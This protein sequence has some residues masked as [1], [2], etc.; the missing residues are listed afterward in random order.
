MK[1]LD[2]ILLLITALLA[3]YQVVQGIA[4]LSSMA[5]A[6]YTI[7][8]GV[9]VI[10]SLM[11]LIL[12]FEVLDSPLVVIASTLIPL[13]LALG[14]VAQFIRP[15][16]IPYGIFTVMGF[17]AIVATRL[18]G[19]KK[20]AVITLAVVHGVAGLTIFFLP[21]VIA[22][23][24]KTPGGFAWVGIGGMLIGLGGLLLSFLKAGKPLLSRGRILAVFPGLLLLTTA[25]FVAG[26]TFV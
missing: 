19:P 10:A 18:V 11:M 24:A 9:I 6:C 21:I 7:G 3:S 22:F 26:F 17:L 14:L 4:G 1:P 20:L 2:R 15:I 5:I 8:F 23:Q 25:A 16:L 12:G 13:S